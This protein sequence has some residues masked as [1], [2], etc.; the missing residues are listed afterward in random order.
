MY[1]SK[2]KHK[3]ADRRARLFP[4]KKIVYKTTP[5]IDDKPRWIPCRSKAP[6]NNKGAVPV[7]TGFEAAEGNG[8]MNTL[9][10]AGQAK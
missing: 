6:R 5:P 3:H 1:E 7:Q 2:Y 4:G 10:P 8:I 9:D